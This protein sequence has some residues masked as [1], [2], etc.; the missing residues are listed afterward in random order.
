MIL[1]EFTISINFA[2]QISN[3]DAV[4]TTFNYDTFS[5]QPPKMTSTTFTKTVFVDGIVYLV[6]VI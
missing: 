2:T 4:F 6:P 3:I 1:P 5:P